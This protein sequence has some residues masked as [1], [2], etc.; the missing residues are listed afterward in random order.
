MQRGVAM[1]ARITLIG[2]ALVGLLQLSPAGTQAAAD[3][4]AFLQP[5]FEL[6]KKDRETLA[7]RGVVARGLS[8][9]RQQV[10]VV[11]ACAVDISADAF[12]GAV[13]A[14]GNVQR[15][16]LVG[17]RLGDPPTIDDLAALTLDQGDIER[18]R[19]CRPGEC[20][21][22]L[23]DHEM[24]ALQRALSRQPESPSAVQDGFRR[25][26]LERLNLYRSH[27]LTAVPD[28]HDRGD[29]VQP[30]AV[31]SQILQQTPYLKQHIPSL[32]EY[33]ERFPRKQRAG[34]ESFFHW[35]KVIM[36]KK[37]VVLVADL[38]TFRPPPGPGVP[39]VLLAAK[40]L[41]ASRYMNG[42]LSLWMLH[43]RDNGSPSYLVYVHRSH[44]D[45]LGGTLNAL[46]RAVF[47][48]GIKD[49]AAGALARL[50][51]Q[52]EHRF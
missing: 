13:R 16:E 27:G 8:A 3:D 25:V 46:K 22:N 52:L 26:V 30:G 36:N 37:P 1:L 50:R 49:E 47:E 40:Q 41:Y 32:L 34:A 29:P 31:F 10:S 38:T 19:Q 44:L 5:W 18:L 48:G 6:N 2:V 33:M 11:A 20:A 43:A 12:V 7:K 35:S 23:A 21:L 51:D 45:E 14:L 4:F 42:E 39:T 15:D 9:A 28:Y 17:G 24:S